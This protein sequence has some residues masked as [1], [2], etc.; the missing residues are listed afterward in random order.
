MLYL[1]VLNKILYRIHLTGFWIYHG[2]EICQDSE[3]IRVLKCQASLRKPYHRDA[4]QSS[5]Y[6]SGST[7]TRIL[8][9]PEL[10]KV[11]KKW[12]I[13]VAWQ[14]SK[15]SSGSEH[16]TV[17]FDRALNMTLFFKWQG[18]RKFCKHCILEIYSILNMPQV[19]NTATKILHVS[20]I[21][22]S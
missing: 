8:N 11:F 4:W 21:L 12:C 22:I 18:Y 5:D 17:L 1:R 9:M 7:Y 6:S 13:I 20:E 15:Y 3:Y 2:F 10:Q 14:D 19:L 16:A